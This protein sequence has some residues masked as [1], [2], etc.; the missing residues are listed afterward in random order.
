[1]PKFEVKVMIWFPALVWRF[2]SFLCIRSPVFP[3]KCL[4][5]IIFLKTEN[6]TRRAHID[7][8]EQKAFTW[9]I[10]LPWACSWGKWQETGPLGYWEDPTDCVPCLHLSISQSCGDAS[11]TWLALYVVYWFFFTL[12]SP[13]KSAPSA[14]SDRMSAAGFP[15]TV[16][17]VIVHTAGKMDCSVDSKWWEKH[18]I[19]RR[20]EADPGRLEPRESFCRPC[21]TSW[22]Y[23]AI[24]P[25][26]FFNCHQ[27]FHW[28]WWEALE[29]GCR[30]LPV[31][32]SS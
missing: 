1:M 31:V 11:H 9:V 13:D 24:N 15:N 4:K 19:P 16:N 10:F 17:W 26:V 30:F 23:L 32:K 14:S 20:D 5:K 3:L 27:K 12:F 7:Q 8:N 28:S 22:C 2:I 18:V 25:T 29:I 6:I 21:T